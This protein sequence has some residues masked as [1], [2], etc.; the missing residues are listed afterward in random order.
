MPQIKPASVVEVTTGT[1]LAFSVLL[2]LSNVRV[3]SRPPCCFRARRETPNI[4]LS[5][6][7]SINSPWRGT[8]SSKHR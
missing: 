6:N 3:A 8:S 7:S 5:I 2:S 1:P 4:L